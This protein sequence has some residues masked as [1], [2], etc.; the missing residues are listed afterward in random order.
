MSHITATGA[1]I[2]IGKIGA[3][4]G[5]KGWLKVH[6]LTEQANNILQYNSWYLGR[7]NAWKPVQLETGRQHGKSLVAKLA[8]VDTP[9]AA[10][11]LT[12][13]NIAIKRKQLPPLPENEFYWADLE[14]L[15]IVDHR[16]TVLGK[17]IYLMA[18]G[19]NDVL[20]IRTKQGKEHGI[21]YLPKRVIKKIDLKQGIIDV[22]WELI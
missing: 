22:E 18:T 17:V 15:T 12:G 2:V 6:S 13:K 16:G 21:P 14:G 9:E 7:G 10:R 19:S 1:F 4:Y 20:I 3:V 11:L 8:G 5:I